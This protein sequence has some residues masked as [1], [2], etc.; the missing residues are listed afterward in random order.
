MFFTPKGALAST[1]TATF[2]LAYRCL[3]C[4]L[5]VDGTNQ[6]DKQL[7]CEHCQAPLTED[8]EV[9]LRVEGND[10]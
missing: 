5:V 8:D 6:E 2:V 7:L 9:A 10:D 4:N 1:D 3:E